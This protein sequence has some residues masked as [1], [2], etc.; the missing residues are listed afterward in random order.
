MEGLTKALE[1]IVLETDP[2]NR[3]IQMVR[4]AVQMECE[5]AYKSSKE[6]EVEQC[7]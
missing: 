1:A 4:K 5:A 7:V 2:P 3:V 6:H